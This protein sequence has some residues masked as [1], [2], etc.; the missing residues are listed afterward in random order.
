MKLDERLKKH[1]DAQVET[2]AK[3]LS[4]SAV[5]AMKSISTRCSPSITRTAS[6]FPA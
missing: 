3:A 2:L 4:P 5:R 1:T 6:L